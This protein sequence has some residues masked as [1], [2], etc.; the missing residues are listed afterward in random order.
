MT[1]RYEHLWMRPYWMQNKEFDDL[2]SFQC[3]HDLGYWV[4]FSPQV[5]LIKQIP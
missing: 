3:V 5:S 4:S 2:S 1:I